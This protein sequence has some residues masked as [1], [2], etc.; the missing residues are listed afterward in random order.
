MTDQSDKTLWNT[1]HFKKC[2]QYRSIRG[3]EFHHRYKHHL[4]FSTVRP[5]SK[6]SL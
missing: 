1:S 5:F 3:S 6:D 4:D 2:S